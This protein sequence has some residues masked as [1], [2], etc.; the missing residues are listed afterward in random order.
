MIIGL[1]ILSA[2]GNGADQVDID[3]A[4]L[5]DTLY[6]QKVEDSKTKEEQTTTRQDEETK[7]ELLDII[8]GMEIKEADE[9]E[10]RDKMDA[11]TAYTYSFSD[12][13]ELAAGT[14][15]DFSF[16]VLEDGTFLLPENEESSGT[17]S[18]QSVEKHP[19]LLNEINH[20]AD[21]SF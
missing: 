2:C 11:Q 10:M 1:T 5:S 18:Y 12:E 13:G 9:K 14:E 20:L 21:I 8:S 16:A 4:Q 19:D 17:L 7:E 3:S 15:S 6:I